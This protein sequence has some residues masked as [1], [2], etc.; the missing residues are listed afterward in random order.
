MK[1]N[2]EIADLLEEIALLLELD[3]ANPFRVR[4]YRNG[5][6]T[7]MDHDRPLAEMVEAEEDL[8]ELEFIGKDLAATIRELV[9][10]GDLAFYEELR[11]RIPDSLVEL[12]RIP[13]LGPGRVRRLWR[14]L[15]IHTLDQLEEAARTGRIAELK[16]FGPKTQE[17]LLRRIERHRERLRAQ[18][19]AERR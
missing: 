1:T 7:V 5:A 12:L 10:T 9:T 16:G 18:S 15:D 8:T 11:A 3:D 6:V 13:G 4:A 17:S 19:D 2:A 14:E